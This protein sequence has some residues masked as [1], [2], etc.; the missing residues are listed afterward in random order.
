[1][2]FETRFCSTLSGLATLSG[3]RVAHGH[4]QGAPAELHRLHAGAS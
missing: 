2:D 3:R 4:A 1:M